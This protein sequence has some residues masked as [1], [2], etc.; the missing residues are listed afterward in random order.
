MRRSSAVA[1]V[2]AVVLVVGTG[3]WLFVGREGST[4][5]G[6]GA[7][8]GPVA[9]DEPLPTIVG[10]SL[11]GEDLSTDRLRGKVGVLNVWATWCGPCRR[12]QPGLQRLAN[13]YGTRVG[14]MGINYQDDRIAAARWADDEFRVSYP[15]LYDPSGKTASQLGYP[16]L[17]DTYVVDRSGTIRWAIQGETNEQE[18]RGLI[19]QLLAEPSPSA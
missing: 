3:V 5:T 2:V 8:T 12:E 17:P 15:S 7:V 11:T 14:F 18:L 19:D 10:R 4:P 6:S 9:M 16:Y 1:I 13:H